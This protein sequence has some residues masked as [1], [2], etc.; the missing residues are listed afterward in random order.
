MVTKKFILHGGISL[1]AISSPAM[2][3]DSDTAPQQTEA[4]ANE[5]IIVTGSRIGRNGDEQPTP[6]TVVSTED[7]LKTSPSS[8]SDALKKLPAFAVSRGPAIQGDATDNFTGNYLNLRG[9]GIQRNLILLDGHRVAPTSYS[10]A[11]D[12]N[13]LPQA[14][15]QRVDIVTGGA[16]AVYGSDAVSGVVNYVLNRKF[17]GLKVDV[18]AGIASRGDA[19]SWRASAAFGTNF[20]ND[21]GHFMASYEHFEQKGLL[22]EDRR[23]GSESWAVAGTGT[24]AD[25]FRLVQG[26]RNALISFRGSL[27]SSPLAGQ[28]FTG[29]GVTGPFV[30]GTPA[31]GTLEVGGEGFYGKGSSALAEVETDQAFGRLDFAVS[32]NINFYAQGIYAKSYNF[33]YF[34]PNLFFPLAVGTDNA[35]LTPATQASIGDPLF[36]FARVFDDADHRI[37]VQS[38]TETWIGSAGLEGN[39]GDF[40]WNVHYQ[41]GVSTIKN[42]FI[43][44]TI[45]G[46]VYA[47]LD[48]VD[49]GQFATGTPNGNIVCRVTLT[50]PTAYPGCVPLNAFGAPLSTQQAGL[51]YV[52]GTSV[53][54]PRW[55]MDN[56]EASFSGTAFENWAGPVRFALS[57]EYRWTS[58][59]VATNAPATLVAD[60]TGIRFNCT[61]GVT[62]YYSNAQVTPI[63]VSENVKEVALEV[64]FPLLRAS[65]VGDAN[66]N[67][68]IRYTDYST[69]GGIT[70][71]KVGGDWAP[72]D[73][74]RFR[75]TYSRDIRA[76][77][78]YDLF[79]PSTIASSGY[80]DIHT[81]YNGI[82]PTETG[83]N[84]GLVPEVAKTLT[85]GAVFR[86]AAVPR[87][88][89]AVDYYR[90]SMSN[91][92]SVID[93]RFASVQNLCEAS[94]G[95][96][97]FCT[98]Y[99]RPLPFSDRT[100]ANAPTLVR[101]TKL[102]ASSLKTWGIDG[103][104]NYSVP[105]GAEGTISFRGL[106]SYQPKLTSLLIPGTT[107]QILA[108][109]AP[110][111]GV[112]GVPKWRL[113]GFLSYRNPDFSI[114]IQE[115]W[116]SSLKRDADPTLVYAAPDVPSVAYTD[117]T[118]TFFPGKD[119]DK[120]IYFSVQNLFDK[121]PPVHVIS[122]FSGTP[123]FQYPAVT[124]DDV[125]GRYFTVGARL[126][127]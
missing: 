119:E 42:R 62:P 57:G 56:L 116:R 32:D 74:L 104:L 2:A 126:K 30:H 85:F 15:I 24:T 35:F 43:N 47:A 75:A 124:G 41:H 38:D 19:E 72:V 113:A 96:G 79:Q 11:V 60:C 20:A 100:L 33:N 95:T 13:I 29:P 108:G 52:F 17:E 6:V 5:S 89:L 93:G 122:G 45:N 27:F 101:S 107:P 3:Q 61:Q 80:Q 91:A 114:D 103:E 1:L 69:S 58:L 55:T 82:V 64:E 78:L 67:G 18:N 86:P 34:Y 37:A 127:F 31:G 50:N 90:I 40:N 71:W 25:P 76:P 12:A 59:D 94:G 65:G 97:P 54:R 70:S 26:A 98:L 88:S 44:N 123:N 39:F 8:I 84:S 120:Q 16:S 77:N 99:D 68:A 51:D 115:R 105:V 111:Q 36:I 121:D 28:V 9:F 73:A 14:L 102:N 21:R 81:G 87:L 10:G 112:G 4:A 125:I 63:D 66:I 117:V 22:K 118:L 106:A 48:A 46:R 7:L 110:I 53:T 49:Q 23:S 109:T 83:G 92:I